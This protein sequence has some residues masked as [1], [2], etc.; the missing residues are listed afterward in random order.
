MARPDESHSAPP[1]LRRWRDWT[2]IRTATLFVLPVVAV[3]AAF[4]LVP[5]IGTL[6]N[7]FYR[8]VTILPRRFIG[9]DHYRD[10]WASQSFRQSLWFTTMFIVASVPLELALGMIFAL[11][12]DVRTVVRGL[13]RACVLVPWAVPAAVSARVWQLIYAYN[14]GAAN[15][16][17]SNLGISGQVNWLGSDVGAFAAVVLA[18]VWK[19][20]PFV[21]IILLANLQAVPR[22]LYYQARV[23]RANFIQTFFHVTLPLVKPGIIAA[24]LFRTIDALRIFDLVYVLTGGGP[25]GSTNSVSLYAYSYYLN[26]SFGYGSAAS[27]VLFLMALVLSI[28][29]VKLGRFRAEGA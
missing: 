23:D 18:D 29:Y 28:L 6:V 4:V 3:I 8:D 9:F 24:L 17:L 7:S 5:V 13:M 14:H 25:G 1:R 20:T 22:E 11:L 21:A 26:G 19:T 27:V 16:L 2:E 10:L 12:L 15:W